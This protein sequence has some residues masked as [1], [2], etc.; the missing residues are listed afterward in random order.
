MHAIFRSIVYVG[1]FILPLVPLLV[2]H[3]MFFPYIT[4]KNFAFRIIV[5]II[6]AAWVVL[7]LLDERYRPQFS[8]LAAAL[9]GFVAVAG[10]ANVFG[11]A[12]YESFWSNFERMEGYVTLLHVL[13][14]FMVAASVLTTDILWTRWLQV[15][16]GVS[17]IVILYGFAQVGGLIEIRQGGVRIDGPF[18]NAAYM[19]V[20]LLFHAFFALLACARSTSVGWRVA[21]GILALCSASLVIGTATRGVM[22][23]LVGGL[24][25]TAGYIGLS[26]E[27]GSRLRRAALIS[28]AVL[29]LAVGGFFLIKDTSFVTE[30][31]A[32]SRLASISLSEGA[33]RLTMWGIALDAASDY[34]LLGR[35]QNNFIYVF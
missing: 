26:G 23:G 7:A 30:H 35:G 18:G 31:R 14:Y 8:S 32:L 10:V 4:G 22:L 6:F 25:V 24:V 15:T 28:L 19:A 21:Y 5:E 16:L 9:V 17:V 11:I 3:D 1:I 27:A 2:M 12:P 20:Y 13:A 29:V 33:T 34:P